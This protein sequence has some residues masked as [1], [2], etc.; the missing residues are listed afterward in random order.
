K[1][2]LDFRQEAGN[3]DR[4]REVL[5]P[6]SRLEVPAV[7]HALSTARLLVLDE[8]QG[9]A[10]R[11]AP[12]G[13]ERRQ[14]ARQLLEAF[15]RQILVDGFFHADPHPGNL[16][17]TGEKIVLIDLGMVGELAPEVRELMIVLLLAFAR[18]DPQFLSEAVLMLAGEEGRSDLDLGELE[19]EFAA[20]LD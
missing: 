15:Y 3:A 16:L 9:T 12:E 1:R 4:L 19:A 8:V 2:E 5:E 20:F 6:F 18:N 11:E 13:E 14:A 10:V 17:W 7:H